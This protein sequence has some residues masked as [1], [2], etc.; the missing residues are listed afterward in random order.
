M[1]RFLKIAVLISCFAFVSYDSKSQVVWQHVDHTGIYEFLDEM[2]NMQYIEL[3][4]VIKPY[5]REFIAKKLLEVN[6]HITQLNQRQK[7]ELEFYIREY[8]KEIS[9]GDQID[10]IGRHY[11]GPGRTKFRDRAKRPDLLYY[12]DSTFML[13]F[14]PILGV[15]VINNDSGTVYHRWN[16]AEVMFY[17]GNTLG[18]YASLRDNFQSRAIN[19]PGMITQE[20]G[21]GFKN[22]TYGFTNR[23]AVEYSE[24]RGGITLNGKKWNVGV[25]K[26]HNVWGNNYNGANIFS[27]RAPSFAQIKLQL[28]PVH[29]FELN[30]FHGWLS[31]KVIDSSAT[32]NYGT[33]TT[34]AYVPKYIAANMITVKPVKNVHVSLGNSIIYSHSFNAAYLIPV[35]FYKSLDHTYSTLGNSQMFLDVSVRSLRKFHFY[36][37]AFFDDFSFGRMFEKYNVTPWSFKVGGRASNI[38]KNITLTAEYTRNY[39]F[40]YKHFNPE[41]T[42][43]NTKYNMGH[44]LRDNAQEFFVQAGYKPLPKF[45]FDITYSFANKGP[46]Y[47]DNRDYKD[48][49]TGQPVIFLVSFQESVI[50]EKSAF[51]LQFRYEVVNDLLL[52]LKFEMTDIRDDNNA[53][54]PERFQGQ[55][56]NTS[57]MVTMGF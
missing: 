25:V 22:P 52:R 14:N 56:L 51:A 44:Y 13:S 20:T 7:K 53:Y 49:I 46:D 33:G 57:F 6:V 28:K 32:Q 8:R 36:G 41:T 23:Q 10:Y 1:M 19:G 45:W 18:V 55:Q 47:I 35:M 30:Y 5:S 16:G 26:D 21:G 34:T 42:F 43:E 2:A 12:R 54:T 27:N 50:W 31:S 15:N 9:A 40:A 37:T 48:P 24:M 11:F 4:T 39:V 29:W 17:G 3:S 38:A